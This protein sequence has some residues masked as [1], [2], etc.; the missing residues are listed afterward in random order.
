MI[1]ILN[2]NTWRR[3][4]FLSIFG[5]LFAATPL[6]GLQVYSFLHTPQASLLEESQTGQAVLAAETANPNFVF[7]VNVPSYFYE[8]ATFKKNAIMEGDLTVNGVATF[9]QGI[10]TQGGDLDLGRGQVTA[11][12]ILYSITAGEGISVT[13]G[14]KPTVSNAGVLSFQGKTGK[15]SLEAGSGISIDGTKISNTLSIPTVPN[16]FGTI[17][18]DGQ[19]DI[20]AAASPDILKFAAGLGISITTDSA[21]RIVTITS[22]TQGASDWT[23]GS[24]TITTTG[25]VGIGTNDPQAQ[26]DVNGNSILRGTVTITSGGLVINSGGIDNNGGGITNA[27]AITGA[28]GLTSSGTITFSDLAIG[29]VHS[30][31]GGVLSSAALN[32]SGGTNEVTGILPLS[33]GGTGLQS[34]LKGDI[35]YSNADNSLATLGVGSQGQALV[36]GPDGTPV[37]GS[38]TG[39]DGFCA[40]CVSLMP[41]SNQTIVATSSAAIGLSIRQP[42]GGSV[43]VFNV[44]NYAG[45]TKY[46][47]I[48]SSGNLALSGTTTYGS[49]SKDQLII[50]PGAAGSN[51]FAGTLTSDD[52]TAARTY[53]LPDASGTFCLTTGNCNGVGG[54]FGGTGTTNY[55][56]KFSNSTTVGNSSIYD[57]GLV[58]IG[59]TSPTANLYVAG[60]T[61]F[62]GNSIVGGAFDASGSARLASS[63]QVNGATALQSTLN[64]AGAATLSATL[65]VTG[66]T[67]IGG[68]LGVTSSSLFTG[69]V[70]IGTTSTSNY[71]FDVQGAAADYVMR[72]R[73]T[74]DGSGVTTQNGLLV[75]IQGGASNNTI[76]KFATGTNASSSIF[77]I[78]ATAVTSAVPVSATLFKA[79][80]GTTLAS[81]YSFSSNDTD[82]GIISPADGTMAF[83]A[84]GTERMRMV[85]TG[86]TFNGLSINSVTTPTAILQAKGAGSTSSTSTFRLINSSDAELLKVLDNGNVG[87]GSTTP[88]A[89]LDIVSSGSTSNGLNLTANSLT[90]GYGAYFSSTSTGLTTGSLLGLD[91]SP[92]STT[93]ATGDLL[94][95]NIGS[96]GSLGN[97]FNVKDNGSSVFSVSQ[98]AVTANLPVNFTSAGDVSMA[99]DLNFTNPIASYINSSAPLYLRSGEVV[100]SSDLTLSTYNKGNVIIDSEAFVARNASISGQLVLGASVAPANIGNFYLTNSST[101]G[102]ALAIFNQTESQDIFTASASGTTRFVIQ[103]NGNVGIGTSTPAYAMEISSS[104]VGSPLSLAFTRV[105]AGHTWSLG[106]LANAGSFYI[107]DNSTTKLYIDSAAGGNVGI[108]TTSTSSKLTVGGTITPTTGSSFD[109]G[110]ASLP[111]NNLYV[112]NII[113]AST[114]TS[115]YWQRA[116]GAISPTNITDD[117]LLG[118]TATASA[119]VKIG[120]TTGANSYFNTGGNVGIGTT[121]ASSLLTV[122]TAANRNVGF[123]NVG[124]NPQIVSKNDV[125]DVYTSMYVDAASL[126]LNSQS[127][128][129]VG[130]GTSTTNAKLEL[131]SSGTT[132]NAFNLTANSLTTGYGGYFSST[133]TGF[134]TGSLLGLDWSPGSATTATGD[135]LSLNI[136][137][138]G[139]LGNI[140]NVKDNGSSVFSVSQTGVTANLPVN[141]TSPGDVSIAYDLGFT[142]PIASYI[143]SGAPLYLRAGKVFNSSDLTLATYN[144]GNVIVDSEAFVA[145]NAT[146]SAQLVLGASVAPANIGNFYLTNSSTFGKA[147]AIL[148][149]T[150][151]ADIFTASLSGTT[152]FVIN[153]SGNIGIGTSVPV[154]ALEVNG[155]IRTDSGASY[156]TLSTNASNQFTIGGNAGQLVQFSTGTTVFGNWTGSGGGSLRLKGPTGGTGNSNRDGMNFTLASGESTGNGAGSNLIFQTSPSGTSG[157]QE[158]ALVERMRID[159]NGNLGIGTTAPISLLHISGGTN[160]GNALA[161]LNQTGSSNNDIL[162]ASASGT[163]KFRINNSGQIYMADGSA[164]GTTTNMLY[165]VSGGLYWNGSQISAAGGPQWVT[166]GSDL[167]YNT[168]NVGIGTTTSAA[169]LEVAGDIQLSGGNRTISAKVPASSGAGNNLSILASNATT[170]GTGGSIIIDA[171]AGA[172]GPGAGSISIG[173]TNHP[174]IALGGATT[175][176]LSGPTTGTAF[177]VNAGGQTAAAIGWDNG[178]ANEAIMTSSGRGFRFTGA[179]KYVF[180]GNVGIGSTTP[181]GK[182]DLVST[183]TTT[184]GFNLTANSLTT[185][186]GSYLS[187]TSTGLTTGSLMGL[188]WSPGSATSATGDLLSLNIGS[189]GLLGNI[190]NVKDNGSSVFSVSQTAVTANL[191]VNFTSAGDVSMAYDLNFTNPVASYINSQSGLTLRAGEVFNSSDLLLSTYNAGNVII[192]SQAFVANQS[193]SISAQLV[194]GTATAPGNIGNFYLTNSST[195]G[196]ALAI[197]NQ[198]ESADIFTASSSGTT[199]F[200]ISS[201]GNIGIGTTSTAN[202]I[203][204]GTDN[205]NGNGAYLSAGGS[206]T[207]G[208]SLSF[209]ENVTALNYDDILGKINTLSISEW[210]YKNENDNVKHI[211][212]I[213]EDFYNIFG[214]G[215]DAKHISTIDPAGIALAGVKALSNKLDNLVAVI[216]SGVEGSSQGRD[217]SSTTQNDI[218][219]LKSD[220]STLKDTTASNSSTLSSLSDTVSLLSQAFLAASGSAHIQSAQDLGLT[221][222][223]ATISGDLTVLGRT[224]LTDLGVTG[225]II[226]GLMSID[227]AEG[228]INVLGDLKLQSNGFGN[229]DLFAGKVTVDH[230]GNITTEGTVTAKAVRTDTVDTE[231]LTLTNHDSSTSAVL[232]ASAG[233][234][235]IPAGQTSVDVTTSALTSNSLIFVTPENP[236]AIGSK[237]KDSDTFTIKLGASLSSDLK[238][239]WW[240]VD[241]KSN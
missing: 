84:N 207:N 52:L 9:T 142:N 153:S 202:P 171:G 125:G 138:N 224:T 144:K 220:V 213:A 165:S 155:T 56:A 106:N 122:H 55:L 145:R 4:L 118:S 140:F 2:T 179:T 151:T 120:G 168:G 16:A 205:T 166:S 64:V 223:T 197:L 98:T 31:V 228:K 175:V 42:N 61:I 14:Q 126:W 91:W 28:T 152:K 131:V 178:T 156:N 143:T 234:V 111:W 37:W 181:A 109:L 81:G 209:K 59:T 1:H 226:S 231:K 99:Y 211:G 39:A 71:A 203:T 230:T 206:W 75:N 163:T 69:N 86:S 27:G 77:T 218:T 229:I 19:D 235:T 62:T 135:L 114:G 139:I 212:P 47:Q 200:V 110:T 128:G 148:N 195:F 187:S 136:G 88:G 161:I 193:A 32:L 68:T 65:N 214:V 63:L 83:W 107:T 162:A 112:N 76:A 10:D 233:K 11:S 72:I 105:G 184:N 167:Y 129:N 78:G 194:V 108:G 216:P 154:Q 7:N 133:S 237:K 25:N 174:N 137:A 45:T 222:E 101:F 215:N 50:A 79:A 8:T 100:D 217:S 20:V 160:S 66:N 188:D 219:G 104:S 185:G 96:N 177:T 57:N 241:A 190:F 40:T 158:N 6:L 186:Y 198:A 170:S 210:N 124:G 26:L 18:V 54:N 74:V 13:D 199:K 196:K 46:L 121:N 180:D 60:N 227:G 38:P 35:L 33:L 49:S 30:G 127:G 22:T 29:I 132:T 90:T 191:P 157:T 15:V 113:G 204:V 95:L 70:G 176:T 240:I 182:L 24:G 67:Q 103:N 85:A 208:S 34:Y 238:V 87:I 97:I 169:K 44:T 17:S 183:G 23:V 192:D 94:S 41:G 119:L 146:I 89:Q 73:N 82:G 3:R 130:I 159:A 5:L 164:P 221:T 172:G 53:T 232:S 189:N 102:K 123:N 115:G 92:G 43:D 134:T 141:F 80:G 117:L 201:T 239:N 147:L 150:E 173:T 51:S 12:N 225:K 36:V 116:G 93:T 236:V 48:D 58:G 21:G 149:Q